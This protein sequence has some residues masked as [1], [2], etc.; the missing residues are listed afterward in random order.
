MKK[1]IISHFYN[2]EYLLPWWLEHHKKI[3]DH[4]IMIDYHSTDESVNIIKRICPEWE[5]ITSRNKNFEALEVDKEVMDIE[6]RV[7]GWRI[8]LNVTEFILGDFKLLK[9]FK[10]GEGDVLI[11]SIVM[12]DTPK[13]EMKPLS[14]K[15]SLFEHRYH[16]VIPDT[17]PKFDIRSSRR[18][19]NYFYPYSPGRHFATVN[20]T[21]FIILWYGFSPFNE[22]SLSRKLQIQNNIPDSDKE[23]GFG[24]QHITNIE[25]QK[26][27]L[28]RLQQDTEDIKKIINAYLKLSY[29]K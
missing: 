26:T 20:T 23:V 12:T 16:G 7:E 19:G 25:E 3:F 8:A 21:S 14:N 17:K 15:L 1:T 6:Q 27:K 28:H 22:K 2:E 5:I 18:L 9:D 29:E 11:P 4:G 13:N 10:E 24:Y